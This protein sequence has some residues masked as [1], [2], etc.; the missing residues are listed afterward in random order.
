MAQDGPRW[1]KAVQDGPNSRAR[2]GQDEAKMGQYEAKMGQDG[3]YVGSYFAYVAPDLHFSD[4]VKPGTQK[5][6]K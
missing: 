5:Q 2:V 3:A 6:K 4:K 1:T